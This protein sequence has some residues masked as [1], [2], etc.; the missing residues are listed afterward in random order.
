M[1]IEGLFNIE[2]FLEFINDLLAKMQPFPAPRSVIVMDNCTI[3]KAPEIQE[4]IKVRYV[5][6]VQLLIIEY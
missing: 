5:R 2:L 4:L 3:H 1:I 6:N